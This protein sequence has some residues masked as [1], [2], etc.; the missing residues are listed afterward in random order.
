[1]LFSPG[2]F[3]YTRHNQ[4]IQLTASHDMPAAYWLREF[5]LAGGLTSY[6]ARIEERFRQV[7]I[8]TGRE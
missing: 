3:F 4:V 2:P 5:P 1:M 6:G 7:G 8:Y